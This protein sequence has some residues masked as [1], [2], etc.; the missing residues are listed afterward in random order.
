[1]G[2]TNALRGENFKFLAHFNGIHPRDVEEAAGLHPA[3][4]APWNGELARAPEFLRG[5]MP[6]SKGH[7]D[8]AA[9]G[10]F[11]SFTINDATALIEKMVANQ[12]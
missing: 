2:K 11:L 12:S 4:P 5:I 3:M 8:A 7:V 10:T 6:I 9:G 1:M